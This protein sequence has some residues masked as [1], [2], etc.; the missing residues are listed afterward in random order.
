MILAC[1]ALMVIFGLMQGSEKNKNKII[2]VFFCAAILFLYAALRS[3]KM[4][5]D[6]PGYVKNYNQYAGYSFQQIL[7]L[8]SSE[9]KDPTYYFLGWLFS[10]VFSDAQFWIAFIALIYIFTIAMVTFRESDN[11]LITFVLLIALGHF[12][13]CLSGL[14]QCLA[15]SFTMLAYFG[16][17]N[18]KPLL[19]ILLVL[20]GSLF[21]RSALVFLIIYPIAR[22]KIG[23]GH[24]LVAII[25][26]ILFLGFQDSIRNLMSQFLEDT[27]YEGYIE[28]EVSLTFSGLIIQG[29]VFLFC[30]LY[31]SKVIAKYKHA[32]ILYNLLFIGL[33]SQI[34]AP[35]VAEFF[36]ISMYFS[37][38]SIILVPLVLSTEN[39]KKVKLLEE[40]AII[41]VSVAYMLMTGIPAYSFFW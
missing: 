8:F 13:F 35:M 37:V 9:T 34:F 32:N 40:V 24:L 17:K 3:P 36:R 7:Q 39:N 30:M 18:K 1:V 2:Y 28:R 29:A 41:L 22:T 15:L 23:W 25:A 38:F 11:P 16:I 33:V 10:R 26:A 4:N 5:I 19:F 6:I 12:S 20:I 21:H 14:R 27:Q 31:Y